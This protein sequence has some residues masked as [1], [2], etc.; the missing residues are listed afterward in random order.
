[1]HPTGLALSITAGIVY[2][3]C[4]L[5]VAIWPTQAL[6]FFSDWIHAADLTKVLVIKSL[7]LASFFR[8]L[9]ETVLFFYVVGVLYAWTYNKCVAHCKKRG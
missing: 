4:G 6:R 9:G 1:M 3:L 7:T 2:V 5:F 8:G